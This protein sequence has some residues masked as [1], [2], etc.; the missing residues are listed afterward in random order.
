[1]PY[2]VNPATAWRVLTVIPDYQT[3]MN[4][5]ADAAL[6]QGI[7]EHPWTE[8]VNNS[9][10]KVAGS[11]ETAWKAMV[12]SQLL[13]AG[14]NEK[15]AEVAFS[16]YPVQIRSAV[17]DQVVQ[18]AAAA[19]A[20]AQ[21]NLDTQGIQ[22]EIAGKIADRRTNEGEGLRNLV[23]AALGLKVGDEL[24]L[25]PDQITAMIDAIANMERA[26]AVVKFADDPKRPV[27]L[28]LSNGDN[29][30]AVRPGENAAEPTPA[31]PK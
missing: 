23:L 24:P 17:P 7:S 16:Y 14:L 13:A 11:I 30:V 29:G 31:P 15:E 22:T 5:Q 4:R 10:G 28:I 18:D 3:M 19:K 26:S 20:A 12:K 8:V 21:Q 6:R 2:S 1:M 25:T 27:T 9:D